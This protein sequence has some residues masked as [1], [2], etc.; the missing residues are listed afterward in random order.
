MVCIKCQL[1]AYAQVTH[2]GLNYMVRVGSVTHFAIMVAEVVQARLS[3]YDNSLLTFGELAAILM[4][5]VYCMVWG[6]YI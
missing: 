2:L 6:D 3:N 5:L 4:T 1:G